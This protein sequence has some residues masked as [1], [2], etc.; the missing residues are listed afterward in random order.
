MPAMAIPDDVAIPACGRCQSEYLDEQTSEAI[1]PRLQ[2]AYLQ[3]LRTRAR[4]AIDILSKHI[5]QRR[6][7]QLL[8]LSQGYLSRIR[9]GAGNPSPELVGHLGILCQDPATRLDELVRFWALPDEEWPPLTAPRSRPSIA[10]QR[11]QARAQ[12]FHDGGHVA[13]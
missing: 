13:R 4:V 10:A 3:S 1:A 9:A 11:A 8:G 7:E 12:L 2:E 6:L 5:S